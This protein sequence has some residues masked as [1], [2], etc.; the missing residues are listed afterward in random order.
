MEIQRLR[1]EELVSIIRDQDQ[2]LYTE[3]VNRYEQKLRRYA[4]VFV[5]DNDKADDVLQSTFIKAFINLKG[6]NTKKKFSSWI[7]RIL[8]NEAINYIKKHK[9]EL[10]LDDSTEVLRITSD[11]D[12]NQEIEKEEIKTFLNE[13]MDRL[14]IKYREP[15]A[16]FY[17]EDYS[18]GEISEIL[19]MPVGTV[20]TRVSRGR[21]LLK[22]SITKNHGQ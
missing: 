8:H 19:K 12:H 4:L 15:L 21:G 7:Y 17:L 11:I 18:Y 9:R 2:E 16:L 5:H 10:S 1:D 13:H 22:K 14:S 6:F 3:I 20:G